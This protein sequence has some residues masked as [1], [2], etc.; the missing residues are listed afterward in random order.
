MRSTMEVGRH[1]MIRAALFAPILATSPACLFAPAALG[2][3]GPPDASPAAGRPIVVP[4]GSEPAQGVR[5]MQLTEAWRAGGSEDEVFFGV[6]VDVASDG[7]G[8]VYLLDGQLNQVFVY[9]D[10][11]QY[12]GTLSKEG[13]G[14]GE[15]RRPRTLLTLPAGRLGILH[16][17][18]GRLTCLEADGTP[19]PD[20]VL[21]DAH[22]EAQHTLGLMAGARRGPALAIAS[23]TIVFGE[24]GRKETHYLAVYDLEGRQRY[25]AYARVQLAF[26]FERR[27]FVERLGYHGVWTLGPD[28]SLYLAP[29]RNLYRIEQ[30]N[31]DGT[32]VR[33]IERDYVARLRTTEEKKREAA[34]AVMTINGQQVPLECDIE[35]RD[36]CIAQ[37]HVDDAGGVWVLH[38]ESRARAA[39]ERVLSYDHFDAAGQF[40]ER[41]EILDPA[42]PDEDRLIML[43]PGRFVVLRGIT[44]ARLALYGAQA[45]GAT[46]GGSE[47]L[48][49]V[50]YRAAG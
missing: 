18:R 6:I 9:S 12:L 24:D 1:L 38:S 36:P 29:E 7:A 35:D 20:I 15:I 19:A 5:R 4:S 33:V 17:V 42:D 3:P 34:G 48:E 37:L 39:T 45:E 43:D 46:E 47:P 14:P 21:R 30:R 31:L 49:V 50:Y 23:F 28:G 13:E 22:G 44:G 40:V 25:E 26:D 10:D 8:H 41:V 32:L 2:E 16:Q 11:G 27:T